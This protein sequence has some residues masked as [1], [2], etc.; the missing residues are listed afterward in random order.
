M[1]SVE[2]TKSGMPNRI[3]SIA[4]TVRGRT[5]VYLGSDESA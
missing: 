4:P 2:V 1:F 3:S 5:L